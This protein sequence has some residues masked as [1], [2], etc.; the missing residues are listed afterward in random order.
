MLAEAESSE[1]AEQTPNDTD[2]EE[3]EQSEYRELKTPQEITKV[4]NHLEN[5]I[6]FMKHGIEEPRHLSDVEKLGASTKQLRALGLQL[7]QLDATKAQN[8]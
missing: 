1:E 6:I 3:E 7:Y 4:L 8:R 2:Q 5:K